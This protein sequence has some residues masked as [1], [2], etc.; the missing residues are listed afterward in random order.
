MSISRDNYESFFID[1]MEG[2]LAELEQKELLKFLELHPDLA[3]EFALLQEAATGAVNVGESPTMDFDFLKKP[4]EI[5]VSDEEMIASLEG[6]L[7]KEQQ[8]IFD[9]NIA[10]YPENASRYQLFLK[11]KLVPDNISFGGKASLKRRSAP[12]IPLYIKWGAIAATLLLFG[13]AGFIFQQKDAIEQASIEVKNIPQVLPLQNKPLAIEKE[14]GPIKKGK[15]KPVLKPILSVSVTADLVAIN[16]PQWI[17]KKEPTT[18]RT[19]GA[20]MAEPKLEASSLMA[21]M[22]TS[23]MQAKPTFLT[24]RDYVLQRIKKEII[25]GN[26]GFS[27]HDE[28]D[29]QKQVKRYGFIS[30]Y[31]AYE[32]IIQTN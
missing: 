15:A 32:R 6:D 20:L 17:D 31:F 11:T 25:N 27:F 13:L 8:L 10:L 5:W 2:T 19:S 30:K 23:T 14:I 18:L 3:E 12:V 1:Y 21:V 16:E 24:P 7:P 29:K 22:E 4:S 28:V 9:R 26:V